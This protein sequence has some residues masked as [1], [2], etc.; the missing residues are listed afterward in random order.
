MSQ[1][2]KMVPSQLSPAIIFRIVMLYYEP[3]AAIAG[4]ILVL[5]CPTSVLS[6]IL[7]PNT[8]ITLTP[9]HHFLITNI[10]SLW[11][12]FGVV[13]AIVLRLTSDLKIWSAVVGAMIFSDLGYLYAR[14]RVVPAWNIYWRVDRWRWEDW[15][16][17]G[18]TILI[19]V[20]RITFLLWVW[21][22]RNERGAKE[23]KKHTEW[24][25][26]FSVKTMAIS[27]ALWRRIEHDVSRIYS[28]LSCVNIPHETSRLER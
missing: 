13:E 11:L 15:V 18:S 4:A 7:P 5:S 8:S 19:L 28:R 22:W 6:G 14:Q 27:G 12:F 23:G 10:A 1:G 2:S 16:N 25:R 3:F 21:V 9:I 26:S 20:M 17:I 24:R